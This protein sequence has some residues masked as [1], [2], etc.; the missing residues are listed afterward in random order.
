MSKSYCNL[1]I[2]FYDEFHLGKEE[3][4]VSPVICVRKWLGNKGCAAQGTKCSLRKTITV[5][6]LGESAKKD[7]DN[8][9]QGRW[10]SLNNIITFP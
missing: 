2:F 8:I 3:D 7:D 1:H 4:S 10:C 6:L 9:V 5:L